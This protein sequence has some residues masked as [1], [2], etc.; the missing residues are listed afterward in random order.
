MGISLHIFTRNLGGSGIGGHIVLELA[1]SF[2]FV[3]I[4]CIPPFYLAIAG[5][6]YGNHHGMVAMY[7]L[8]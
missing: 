5:R 6:V 8:L 7:I 4:L 1:P 2:F 3:Y